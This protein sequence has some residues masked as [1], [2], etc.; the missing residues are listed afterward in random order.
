M[1]GPCCFLARLSCNPPLGPGW[2]PCN[3]FALRPRVTALSSFSFRA[4]ALISSLGCSAGAT[5]QCRQICEVALCPA[6]PRTS[7]SQ[8]P[9][10]L[11]A[12]ALLLLGAQVG[13]R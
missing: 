10:M 7:G 9:K 12:W 4:G 8:T 13:R 3:S 5:A 2:W 11:D 1:T 6:V